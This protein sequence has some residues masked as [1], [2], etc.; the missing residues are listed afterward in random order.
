MSNATPP[1]TRLVPAERLSSI[2][3][4]IA[5]GATFEG[6]FKSQRDLG[7]KIDGV[8]R[9]GVVF[10]SGGTIHVGPS[11]VVDNTRLEADHILIEGKVIGNVFARKG[12]EITGSGTLLGDAFYDDLID[13]HPRAKIRGKVEYRGD[14]DT[15]TT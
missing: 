5:D 8:L 7:I 13:M 1:N 6:D 12:L 3:S 2:G 15:P 10:E 14:I 9:G 4:L 11:G